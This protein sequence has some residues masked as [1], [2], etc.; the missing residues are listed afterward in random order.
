MTMIDSA[1]LL[2]PSQMAEA[3]RLALVGGIRSG[4]LME[5]AG[6]AVVEAIVAR[7]YQRAVLVLCGPGNNGGDGFVVA[8][9][10]KE[11]GWPV[12]LRL[13][14]DKAALKGDAAAMAGQW[15]GR[16]E[17][18]SVKDIQGAD[19]I[20]DALLGAG[21]SRDVEDEL[22]TLIAAINAGGKTVVSVDLPSGVDGA[23]GQARGAAVEA[24]LTVTFF[25]PKPA[26]LLQ[27]GR[28]WCGELV[29][30]DIGIPD[31]VLGKIGSRLWRNE[32]ALW[33]IPTAGNRGNKFSRGHCVVISGGP[34]Q[35]GAAR[36]S[37]WGAFRTGVGLV[38][39]IG[40][41]EAL[42]VHAAHV[43]AIMLRP[44]E[45]PDDLEEL[46]GDARITSI[47]IGPAAGIGRETH[48]SALTALAAGPAVVLDA[49]GITSFKGDAEALFDAIK[50][51]PD[52]AVVLSPHEGEFSRLFG[53]IP[54]SKV[55]RALAAAQRSGACIILKGSDTVITAP[56]GR[57]AINAN[58]PAI[59][60]TAGSGDVLAGIVA[61]FLGQGMAGFEAAAA[62]VWVHAEAANRFGMP[63][64]ISEDLPD[65]LP[66][67]LADLLERQP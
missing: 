41:H 35:G 49:D 66:K 5:A 64:L 14:G 6:L 50:A 58:A 56:D 1:V 55:E 67:V 21:L 11:R 7:Y 38:T 3:D 29:V 22:K 57:A 13:L 9:L 60:G 18:P 30:A 28:D 37:A 61:G 54:G 63:G 62:G 23:T 48:F 46:L 17:A 36:L 42:L 27:P 33:R 4:K 43:S 51:R 65:M 53:D 31:S 52:R 24:E 40:S 45:S 19:L 47:V 12:Q 34:L 2:T 20:V 32:P 16:I 25:R 8:R 26:H 39:L 44:A 15:T 10:L 59:L